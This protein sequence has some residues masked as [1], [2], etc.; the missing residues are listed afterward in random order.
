MSLDRVLKAFTKLGLTQR[1]AEIY[2]YLAAEGPREAENIAE[3][4]RLTRQQVSISLKSLRKRRIVVST[5]RYSTR[6][7]ALPFRR[8]MILLIKAKKAE[9]QCIEEGKDRILS[10]WHSMVKSKSAK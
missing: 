2:V 6:F 4:L 5:Y 3:N 10:E 8:V 9:A 7:D 1:E